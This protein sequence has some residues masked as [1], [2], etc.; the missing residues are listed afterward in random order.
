MKFKNKQIYPIFSIFLVL[1]LLAP[2][3]CR[4]WKSESEKLKE[5][6]TD[7]STE[8]KKLKKELDNLKTENSTMHERL[9]QLN[10]RMSQLQNEIQGLKKDLDSFKA[11]V[12][13]V[14]Q[15]NK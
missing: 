10:L 7:I 1:C 4:G 9:A 12:K 14:A 8:N 6:I 15:K 11:Q 13:R 2:W 3:G 5:E